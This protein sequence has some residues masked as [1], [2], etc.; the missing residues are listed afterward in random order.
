MTVTGGVT[1][2][3]YTIVT[4]PAASTDTTYN[5]LNPPDVS[6]TRNAVPGATVTQISGNTSQAGGTATFT[7]ALTGKPTGSMRGRHP[8]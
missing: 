7:I 1:G 2:G 8:C 3:A 5:N 4:G 6:V